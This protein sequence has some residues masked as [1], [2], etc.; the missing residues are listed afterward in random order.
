MIGPQAMTTPMYPDKQHGRSSPSDSRRQLLAKLP[1]EERRLELAGMSTS[2]LEGGDG[3]PIVLLHGPAGYA[4][5]WMHLIPRLV[6]THRVIAPDLPGHGASAAADGMDADRVIAWLDELIARTCPS[7]PILV[8]QLLGG[9]IALRFAIR[10]SD[11][12]RGLVLVDTFGLTPFQPVPEFGLALTQFLTQPTEQTHR[13]LWRY[14]AFDL[15]S[16]RERMAERWQP[17]ESYNVDRARAP[18][19]Q[20]ALSALMQQ[21]GMPAIPSAELAQITVP[22]SLIWGR[23]DRATP[24]SVAEAA[25]DRYGWPLHVIED[26]ADDPPIERPEALLQALRIVLDKHRISIGSEP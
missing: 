25:S 15:S 21:F 1:V 6:P 14:C 20:A 7:P 16:L 23:H 17:F 22:T 24:I 5:H 13:S 10:D 18:S 8:G 2:V 3:P 12:L 4:A 26:S 9:A 11:R 19:V